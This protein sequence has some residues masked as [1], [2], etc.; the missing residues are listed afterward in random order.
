[1]YL[2]PAIEFTAYGTQSPGT[3]QLKSTLIDG[4]M[5]QTACSLALSAKEQLLRREL[6]CISSIASD[7][8]F[9]VKYIYSNEWS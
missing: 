7:S 6:S 2:L 5:R 1:M 8:F 3:G 4:V 9:G